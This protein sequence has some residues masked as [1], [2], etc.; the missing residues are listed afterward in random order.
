MNRA[1][2]IGLVACRPRPVRGDPKEFGFLLLTQRDPAGERVDRHRVI[3]A[4]ARVPDLAEF[5]PGAT[6]YVEGHVARHGERSRISVIVERAWSIS[7][8]PPPPADFPATS[9]H[10]SPR[11]HP[12]V[13][14]ARRVAIG[15]ARERVVW[16][17]PTTVCP[18][19]PSLQRRQDRRRGHRRTR[20]HPLQRPPDIGPPPK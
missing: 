13:G 3:L 18:H 8:P 16:V 19:A 14:H 9:S 11:E 15:T 10:A 5:V 1:C 6:A 12:R 17:R 20:N 7:P 4:A 2:L